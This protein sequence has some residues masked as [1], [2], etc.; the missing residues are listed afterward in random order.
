MF[1]GLASQG[2]LHHMGS[3]MG[4]GHFDSPC[5]GMLQF[6]I[7]LGISSTSNHSPYSQRVQT[8]SACFSCKLFLSLYDKNYL[9]NCLLA[10]YL[11][12]LYNKHINGPTVVGVTQIHSCVNSRHRYSTALH[13][14][15]RIMFGYTFRK[16]PIISAETTKHLWQALLVE[17]ATN[18][19]WRSPGGSTRTPIHRQLGLLNYKIL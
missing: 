9:I 12:G 17:P 18:P 8:T 16:R 14:F 13:K 15:A 19:S 10:E 3:S 6:V 1:T 5:H 7:F 11:L 2:R 4:V